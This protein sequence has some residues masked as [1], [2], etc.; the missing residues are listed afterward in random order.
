MDTLEIN[1]MDELKR[2]ISKNNYLS[3]LYYY[4]TF[5]DDNKNGRW[6]HKKT[7][8]LRF[9]HKSAGELN[10]VDIDIYKDQ[11]KLNCR[12]EGSRSYTCKFDLKDHTDE[13]LILQMLYVWDA[14]FKN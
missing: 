2:Y 14:H 10:Q 4:V 8:S 3:T 1:S 13:E 11:G 12:S 6:S 7:K 5:Y 9:G